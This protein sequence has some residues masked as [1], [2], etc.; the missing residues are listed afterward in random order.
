M[1]AN[2][3]EKHKQ[4]PSIQFTTVNELAPHMNTQTQTYI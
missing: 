3:I 1:M 4:K 2:S